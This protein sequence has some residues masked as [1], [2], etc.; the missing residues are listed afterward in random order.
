MFATLT[1]GSFTDLRVEYD[2]QDH[3]R[4]AGIRLD[5]SSVGIGGMSDGTAM[6][7]QPKP[8]REI[9]SALNQSR[10]WAPVSGGRCCFTRANSQLPFLRTKSLPSLRAAGFASCANRI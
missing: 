4:L 10:T 9:Y 5:Q 1:L 3:A 2:D 7:P 6:M 8:Q